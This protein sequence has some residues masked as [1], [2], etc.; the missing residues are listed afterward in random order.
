MFFTSWASDT[1][2]FASPF[3]VD[4]E[5][6]HCKEDA[7][8]FYLRQRLLLVLLG[9]NVP[10]IIRRMADHYLLVRDSHIYGMMSGEIVQELRDQRPEIRGFELQMS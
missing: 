1:P 10:L 2:A 3:L 5:Y 9:C 7:I 4:F 8:I 6:A